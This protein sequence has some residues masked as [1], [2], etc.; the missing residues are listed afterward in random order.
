MHPP[1]HTPPMVPGRRPACRPS[2]L[3][4]AGGQACAL[5]A[6]AR[7]ALP[8]R[9]SPTLGAE[10]AKGGRLPMRPAGCAE[11]PQ[12]VPVQRAASTGRMQRTLQD[13]PDGACAVRRGFSRRLIWKR[14][15]QPSLAYL[16]LCSRVVLRPCSAGG[17]SSEESVQQ[18]CARCARVAALTAG[19]LARL[20]RAEHAR[21]QGARWLDQPE[22]ASPPVG[23]PGAAWLPARC[24]QAMPCWPRAAAQA[25]LQ[26][27]PSALP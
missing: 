13:C 16:Q 7:G 5:A 10:G 27:C 17:A 9:H 8:P 14:V 11:V 22:S 23:R 3:A 2:I 21:A 6:P 20:A 24:L 25:A 26:P 15:P 19:A 4:V 18:S 1:A 12:L